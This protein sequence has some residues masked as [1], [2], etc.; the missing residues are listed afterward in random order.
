MPSEAPRKHTAH[1]P[2]QGNLGQGPSMCEAWQVP[3]R[4][5]DFHDGT[6]KATGGFSKRECS[7]YSKEKWGR[8]GG[9][10]LWSRLLI[11][12]KKWL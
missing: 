3:L 1:V 4:S 9:A 5:L 10:G 12:S 6:A 7:G 11:N 8:D 2:H